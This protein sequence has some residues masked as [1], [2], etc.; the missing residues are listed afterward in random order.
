MI[1]AKT[2]RLVLRRFEDRDLMDLYAYLSDPEVVRYEPYKPM[3]LEETRDNLA[4]RITAEEMIAVELKETGRLIGNVYMGKAEFGA[5]ELGYV[6]NR[7]S[8]GKGYASEACAAMVKSAFDSG[9]HRVFAQC[10]AEN[11][12]S[13]RLLERLG[14]RREGAFRKNVYFWTDENGQPI[15][16]DSYEY[17]VLNGEFSYA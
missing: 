2:Q 12:A 15:W 11:A 14:F 6:F 13:Y 17:A 7:G 1:I 4:W 3:T 9:V 10:D 8:W 16:K 5:R